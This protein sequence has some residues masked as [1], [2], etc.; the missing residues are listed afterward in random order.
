MLDLCCQRHT[1]VCNICIIVI[2]SIRDEL[3]GL[4]QEFVST[5]SNLIESLVAVA[6]GK[7]SRNPEEI[8]AEAIEI[9]K[10]IKLSITKCK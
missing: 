2:M 8:M 10:K 9:D 3:G 4:L 6:D 7:K 5:S 1:C